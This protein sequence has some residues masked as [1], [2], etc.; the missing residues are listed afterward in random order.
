MMKI[1]YTLFLLSI[2]MVTW[3]QIEF[4][5]ESG[6]S[7]NT[8]NQI[9]FPNDDNSLSDL[10]DVTEDL[11]TGKTFFYRIRGSYTINDKHVI[12]ALYAPLQFETTGQFVEPVRFGNET[13]DTQD[14]TTVS[15]KFNSYRLTYRY[16]FLNKKKIKIGAGLT[17]KIRDARV[18]FSAEDKADETT[19][20]GVV[21]L[22]NFSI[23]LLPNNAL[24]FIIIG[25]ALVGT[26]GRAEDVF[27]GANYRVNE[28]IKFKVGYRVLEGG[29]DVDQ[30]YNFSLIHYA[31]LGVIIS[32]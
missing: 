19:D 18:A 12:S 30:V 5:V 13:F 23:E 28:N 14:R 17:G 1:T 6:I 8:K 31:A 4:D 25:D 29:A 27:A 20:L 22:I 32:L 21:P 10:L 24:S 3:A 15:Y 2:T 7:W 9:R 26:Q 16:V 11:G